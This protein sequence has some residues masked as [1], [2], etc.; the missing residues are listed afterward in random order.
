M[1]EAFIGEAQFRDGLRRYMAKHAYSNA[2]SADLW[3]ALEA[4]SNKP[5]A[6]IAADLADSLD[7]S[8]SCIHEMRRQ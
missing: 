5:I 8:D 7:T 3:A 2:T 6:A 1:L 4:A